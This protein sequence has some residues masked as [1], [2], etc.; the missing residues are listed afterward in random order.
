MMR[1]DTAHAGPS[2][3]PVRENRICSPSVENAGVERVGHRAVRLEEPACRRKR[4]E[5]WQSCRAVR[6]HGERVEAAQPC[7]VGDADRVSLR[8]VL[9]SDE[10]PVLHRACLRDGGDGA[11]R[12]GGDGLAVGLDAADRARRR[13]GQ[14]KVEGAVPGDMDAFAPLP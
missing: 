1:P 2:A 14:V 4:I 11:V 7:P 6:L 8:R 5:V 13:R 9:V 12:G 3:P 10:L